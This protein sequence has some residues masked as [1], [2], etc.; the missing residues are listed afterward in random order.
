MKVAFLSVVAALVLPC[1]A[2]SL[3]PPTLQKEFSSAKDLKLVNRF[4][5][6]PPDAISKLDHIPWL[7]HL[8]LADFGA[9]WGVGDAPAAGLPIGQHLFSGVSDR[10]VA[11][12][13][14]TNAHFPQVRLLLARRNDPEYCLFDLRIPQVGGLSLEDVQWMARSGQRA[15]ADSG[16]TCSEQT[17]REDFRTSSG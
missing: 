13:F 8:R 17:T 16:P 7:Q 6:L 14:F 11:V 15:A 4:A 2:W 1:A 10:L 3:N 5:D 9:P 12:V